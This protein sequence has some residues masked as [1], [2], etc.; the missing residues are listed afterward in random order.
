MKK[1]SFLH[2]I[3][4]FLLVFMVNFYPIVGMADNIIS[5]VPQKKTVPDSL[6]DKMFLSASRY[7]GLVKEYEGDL[8]LK[9][10]FKVHHQNRI[11]RYLP[12][13]FRLEKGIKN[14]V[15]E[16]ISELHYTAPS[17]YDRKMR[18]LISTFPN[19]H[20][21][22]FDIMDYMKF[23]IYSSSVMG[24][25]ILSPLNSSAQTH[26]RY[27]MDTIT[28]IYG[29]PIY[30]INIVPRYKSTQLLEGSIWMSSW[31]WTVKVFDLRGKYD[32]VGFRMYMRMGDTEETKYLP[33]LFN[34]DLDFKFLGNHL[35]MNYTGWMRYNMVKF[36]QKGEVIDKRKK[37]AMLNLSRSYTLTCDTSKLI[38]DRDSFNRLRPIPLDYQEDTLYTAYVRRIKERKLQEAID[39]SLQTRKKKNLIFWGQLG[40]A[41]ISSYDID[42]PRIGNVRC[43]PLINP[44][45]I[46]YS[47]RRG[48]SYRQV[49]KFNKLFY[50][51]RHLRIVPQIGYNFTKK[52]F[53]AKADLKYVYNP[54]KNGAIEINAGN[55]NRIYSSL[56]LD[57]LKNIPDS[58]FSFE[59]L[60]L[61]YFKDI[62]L[63]LSHNIEIVNG[64]RLWTGLAMHWRYTK[65]T[66]NIEQRV[67]SHYNSFAPRV[68]VEWT[69]YMYYYMN[70]NRKIN[71]GSK[72][73][74]FS[75]D[76]ERG[77]KILDNS[78]EYERIEMSAEQVI[79]FRK[80]HSL[81]YHVGCG[82]FT[83]QKSTYFVDY[84]N[85]SYRN[86]PEGWDDDIGGTFQ[87]LDRRWY[88]SSSHYMSGNFTFESPFILLYPVGNLLSFIQKERIYGGIL[89]MPHLN[90]YFELG[91]GIGTHVFDAGMFIGNE[92]GKFTSVGFKFTFELFND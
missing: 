70:G 68:R 32:L 55:G 54:R 57:Q 1:D 30:K 10:H 6:L 43:S 64:L 22:T 41:L 84:V 61:D 79:H 71:V 31:D 48:I 59:G 42:L 67:R 12:S 87:M 23:N 77:I 90:P 63:N 56:V 69:P 3:L 36:I 25:K 46:S 72:F 85:F 35:E 53:Y 80:L 51:G 60:E 83:N 33:T 18:A 40:D 20:S 2:K 75:L 37:S 14:Y 19:P 7:S 81:A 65:N 21:E 8:Y 73:P 13:M 66:P 28:Y 29:A 27:E 24:D 15:H 45:L 26:Y 82:F 50:N 9:G 49:F 62:Y 92:R 52:E 89:F 86:L 76:Y 16:S 88:N 44:V 39:D 38:T 78:G 91:Y 4:G 47:H 58:T 34:L 5:L 74:T 11:M 17:I